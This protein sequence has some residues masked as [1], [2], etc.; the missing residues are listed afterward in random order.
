MSLLVL[1]R[2]IHKIGRAVCVCVGGGGVTSFS[3]VGQVSATAP[4]DALLFCLT[5]FSMSFLLPQRGGRI[6]FAHAVLYE[7]LL[8]LS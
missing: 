3:L 1:L 4:F 7:R 8:G 5:F 6:R 2:L